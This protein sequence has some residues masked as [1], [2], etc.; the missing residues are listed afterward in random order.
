[1]SRGLVESRP[2]L[3]GTTSWTARDL[4]DP[5]I[6][7]KWLSGRFE[8]IEGVLTTMA[9]AYFAGSRA[10]QELVFCLKAH[11][12]S[13][14]KTD[15]F[16]SELDIIL[17]DTRVV[18]ADAAW[19]TA[20]DL[21][22]QARAAKQIGLRDLTRTRILV[23]PTLIIES[24]SPGHEHHDAQTK[25]KWYAEFGV[26]NYW[27]LD[28]FARS[29]K[30]MTLHGKEYRIDAEGQ[31]QDQVRPSLFPDLIIALSTLWSR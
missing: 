25:S 4:D 21:K 24:I 18:V 11:L 20:A 16:A 9:P 13:H 10:I 1:M 2:F 3:P 14:G 28:G 6:E 7:S 23:P 29:L 31:D 17:D 5:E 8:I 26:P 12:R 19:L 30:C 27:I 15:D 22:K